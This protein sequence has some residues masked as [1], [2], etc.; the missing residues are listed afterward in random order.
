VC[1]VFKKSSSGKKPLPNTSS[2]PSPLDSPCNTASVTE[3]GELDAS[4]ILNNMVNPSGSFSS[5]QT[6][7][8]SNTTNTNNNNNRMDMNLYM[9]WMLEREAT[10]QPMLPWPAGL[11]GTGLISSGQSILKGSP[12]NGYQAAEATNISSL[13]FFMGQGQHNFHASS[14]KGAETVQQH[15][16]QHHEHESIWRGY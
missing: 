9:N 4:S 3:L 11:M 1:R 16:Q 14:S 6:N 8:S 5:M 7:E 10:S 15:Q 12:F 2:L 13:N